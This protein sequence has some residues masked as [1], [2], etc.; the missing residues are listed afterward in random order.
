MK[1]AVVGAGISGLTAAY[2][3]NRGHEV[4]LFERNDYAGGHANTVTIDAGDRPLGLDTGF[5]VYNEHT[6]PG[7][8]KLLAT[9]EVAH[10][11]GRHVD[12]RALPRVPDGI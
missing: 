7:F 5:I 6:Y 3:L 1:I 4:E 12:Q 9:L 2:L 11:G 10:E 8:T